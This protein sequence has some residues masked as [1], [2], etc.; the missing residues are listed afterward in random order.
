MQGSLSKHIR[1]LTCAVLGLAPAVAVA[2]SSAW[3]AEPVPISAGDSK[4]VLDVV[5]KG[6]GEMRQDLDSVARGYGDPLPRDSKNR[7]ERRLREGEIHYL[8][9]D[10]LRAS[11]VLL[12]VVDDDSNKTHPRYNDCVYFLAES[13]RK[14]ENYSGARKYFEE[15][16]PSVTGDRLK[17]V[18]FALLEIA[19]ETGRYDG[20]DRYV[21]RLRDAGG[22]SRPDVDYIHGKM[23]FRGAQ[24]DAGQL[25]RAL[26]AFGTVP[27]GTAVSPQ[28]SYYSGVVLVSLQRLQDAIPKFREAAN[29]A[30]T[31]PESS[32]IEELSYM[33]LGRLHHEMG[34][35]STALDVYQEIPTN[36]PLFSDMLFEAAWAHVK[37]ANDTED[38]TAREKHLTMA[39]RTS[40]ILMASAPNHQLYPEA[41]ILEGNLQIQLGAPETAYDTFQTIIDRYG[42]AR[43][44][45][46]ELSGSM[47]H[48]RDFFEQIVAADLRT[49][50][51]TSFLPPVAIEWAVRSP[52]VRQA[53]SMIQD[54]REAEAFLK[55][56]RGL[57]RTMNEAL[58]GEQ[59]YAMF[60]GLAESRAKAFS[61]ENRLVLLN[62]KLL[63]LERQMVL[64][65]VSKD[66]RAQLDVTKAK[67]R[68]LEE[69]VQDLPQNMDQVA[70]ATNN[71]AGQY[72]DVERRV[73]RQT[74]QVASMRAQVAAVEVWMAQNRTTLTDEQVQ[75]MNDRLLST[76]NA[77]ADIESSIESLQGDIGTA[78]AISGGDG[79]RV[80]AHRVREAYS[81]VMGQENG[82]LSQMRARLPGDLKSLTG[83]IDGQR[84]TLA[85]MRSD[86]TR[87]Q[88]VLDQQIENKVADVREQLVV[89]LKRLD[90]YE[91]QQTALSGE[92]DSMLGPVAQESLEAVSSEFKTIVRKADV[93][94]IDVAWARKQAETKKVNEV[95]QKQQERVRELDDEFADVLED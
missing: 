61:I 37:A 80:R 31:M 35:I 94:I 73:F 12:D 1:K 89:E 48:P 24:G 16:L 19:S 14:T 52:Q 7:L 27:D 78:R 49:V 88:T 92:T 40:E 10:Y 62:R 3:A 53:V 67:R 91:A 57:I 76:R 30:K 20:V 9:N 58:K 29:R 84:K 4:E 17:D 95:V 85:T 87:L 18:V 93:G 13:L 71:I 5:E 82:L 70:K 63:N 81:S 83:R 42:G 79:G 45:L 90:K 51:T 86:L 64:P 75:L 28:A 25:E 54:V 43:A 32:G 39:L 65:S 15:I 41:R 2:P 59:R 46:D 69:E 8:L 60:T 50:R 11:I 34:D 66:G 77:I 33:A 72:T 47:G 55:E 44:K 26:T 21:G 23:L 36:S 6:L 56:S 68:A 74:Y 38:E 22:L